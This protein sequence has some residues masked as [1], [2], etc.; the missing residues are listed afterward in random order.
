MEGEASYV[1]GRHCARGPKMS[2]FGQQFRYIK[3]GKS[4]KI[5][6]LGVVTSIK[7]IHCL[8]D[9]VQVSWKIQ[10]TVAESESLCSSEAFHS[11][12]T[13]SCNGSNHVPL[14]MCP[15][16]YSLATAHPLKSVLILQGS[17][18][19]IP[20]ASKPESSSEEPGP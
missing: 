10:S 18:I 13:A 11:S 17:P 6:R 14:P 1:S 16:S 2:K 15:V 3:G 9:K 7:I 19:Q 20:P 8:Q 12:L 4:E 5:T